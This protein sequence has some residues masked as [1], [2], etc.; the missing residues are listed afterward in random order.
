MDRKLLTITQAADRLG[1]NQKTLRRWTDAGKVP[2]VKTLAGQRRFEPAVIERLRREMGFEDA[3]ESAG[4][5]PGE[6]S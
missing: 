1:V 4:S 5:T 3:E 2:C 6:D